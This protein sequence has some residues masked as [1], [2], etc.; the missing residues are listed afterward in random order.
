MGN[1]LG[2]RRWIW[3]LSGWLVVSSVV[4]VQA[5]ELAE[6]LQR[7]RLQV[8]V[9]Q[10]APPLAFRDRPTGQLQGLEIDLAQQ[11]AQ[12]LLGDSTALELLPV[13]N[14]QRIPAVLS[15]QVDLAIAQLTATPS[16]TRI[17]NFSLPYYLE[18]TGVITRDSSVQKLRDFG[19]RPIAILEGSSAIAPLRFVLPTA[20]LIGVRSYSEAQMQLATGTVQAVAG[21]ASVLIGWQRQT[22]GYVLLPEYVARYPIAIAMPKGIQYEPLRQ[23]VNQI[24]EGWQRSGWLRSRLQCW[25]LPDTLVP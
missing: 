19:Q 4:P 2:R 11:L 23:R 20:N 25:N 12:E 24:I 9:K 21:D 10:N 17:V 18:A 6:I 15:G 3:L 13:T 16:R 14:T 1:S 8:A 7:G 5:A 22:P